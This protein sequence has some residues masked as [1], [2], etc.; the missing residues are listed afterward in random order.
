MRKSDDI[1]RW[2]FVDESG[3]TA[4][5]AKRSKRVI[6][7]EN[8]CPRV[9]LL[10]FVR[11]RDPQELRSKLA[12]VRLEVSQSKYLKDIPSVQKSLLHFHAKDD[13]PEVRKLVYEAIQRMQFSAQ[14][15]VA[16]KDEDMFRKL[17]E[18][19]ENKFYDDL[20]TKL[21]AR[22][23]HRSSDNYIV[24]AQRGDKLRQR[25]LAE[26]VERA[27]RVC[28]P[29][30]DWKAEVKTSQPIQ[31]PAIQVIDY[32]NWAVQRAFERGEMRYFEFIREKFELI[33]DVF[34]LEKKNR[35]EKCCYDRD[36]NPF[37]VKK[38]SPL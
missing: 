24:F 15:V 7:G 25:A 30:N 13:C 10:G 17:Y 23:L 14:I 38:T 37:D 34:D 16:R 2:Y 29:I 5:Y 35:G 28:P 3:D 18:A 36:K 19:N 8:G 11:T 22:Q 21:F 4:F 31:E 12:E 1:P 9:L 27:I 20:V 6:V 33:R 32:V 26:A